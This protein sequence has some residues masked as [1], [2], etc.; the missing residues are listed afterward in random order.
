M[1]KGCTSAGTDAHIDSTVKV[2]VE[3]VIDRGGGAQFA[4]HL[5]L[6]LVSEGKF[7]SRLLQGAEGGCPWYSKGR[8]GKEEI[9]RKKIIVQDVQL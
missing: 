6:V 3:R 4:R 7:N 1:H 9:D 8:R 2:R 5:V